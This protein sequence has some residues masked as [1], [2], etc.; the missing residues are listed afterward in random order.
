[1]SE[2]PSPLKSAIAAIFHAWLVTPTIGH[3]VCEFALRQIEFAPV[4]VLRHNRSDLPSPS[5]SPMPTNSHCM[6]A[7]EFTIKRVAELPEYHTCCA[8]VLE[9]RQ[10]RS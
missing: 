3:L 2:A 9:L 1:M 7:S 4:T 6:S 8:P 10:N 5:K